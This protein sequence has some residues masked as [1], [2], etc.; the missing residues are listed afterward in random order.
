MGRVLYWDAF[1]GISG[2]M[3]LGALIDLG[4][5]VAE[6]QR[7]LSLLS[8]SGEF[9]LEA[10]KTTRSGITGTDVTVH[11]HPHSHEHGHEHAHT[12]R[13]IKDILEILEQSP[14]SLG[15]KAR[16][17]RIFRRVAEAEAKVH[18]CAVEDVHFHEVG[19][20]DSIVDTIGVSICMEL[21]GVDEIICS[22]LNLGGGTV[23]CAHGVLP[24]P[25]P[26]TACILAGCPTYGS[27]PRFGELVTPTGAAIARE[28]AAFGPQPIMRVERIGYGFGKRDTGSLNAVRGFLG[29]RDEE[30]ASDE[31]VTLLEA[32]LDDMTGETLAYVAERLFEFGALDVWLNPVYMKKG[33]PGHI[34]C[35]LCLPED[36]GRLT[37][38]IFKETTTWGVR[39]GV[40]TRAV[41]LRESV[42]RKTA[43]GDVRLKIG[44]GKAKP[45]YADCAQIARREDVPVTKVMEAAMIGEEE[46]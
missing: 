24:V 8:V 38:R 46:M 34:L 9:S 17:E 33:R 40:L 25:A 19:A 21:L 16:A 30:I 11:V 1:S 39:K 2:D 14:L 13:G 41:L 37:K 18:G 10:E 12:H 35:C 44:A 27:D 6:L 31:T 15:V 32:N 43:Y 29:Y 36:A 23:R 5:D 26:A 28:A 4:A 22:P 3:S 45:E 7:Q 20:T 42:V